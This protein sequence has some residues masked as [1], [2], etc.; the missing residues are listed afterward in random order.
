M[1]MA[2]DLFSQA[3]NLPAEQ[4][5]EL[6]FLLLESLPEDERPIELDPEYEAELFRRLNEMD[7]GQAKLLSLAQVMAS[8]RR[9]PTAG[10]MS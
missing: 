5:G 7:S 2:I 3:L 9:H 4:R 6:A 1:S 8:L 10:S